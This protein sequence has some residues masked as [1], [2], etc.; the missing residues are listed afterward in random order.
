MVPEEAAGSGSNEGGTEGEQR[1]EDEG[2]RSAEEDLPPQRVFVV[3][4]EPREAILRK[5]EA[6]AARAKR[7]KERGAK[8]E[9]VRQAEAEA[10]EWAK[11]LREAGGASPTTLLFQIRGEEKK[12]QNSIKAIEQLEKRILEE[13]DEIL[14][15]RLGIQKLQRAVERHGG[16]LEASERR[17]AYLTAQK[18]AE[19]IELG[20]ISQ[21]RA[22]AAL[23]ASQR[24]EA[25]SPILEHLASILPQ[26]M[27]EMEEGDTSGSPSASGDSGT[28]EEMDEEGP[29][30]QIDWRQYSGKYAVQLQSARA[31]LRAAQKGML[32][33]VEAARGGIRETNKR[34]LGGDEPKEGDREGDVGMVPTL[35]PEQAEDLHRSRVRAAAKEYR[36]LQAMAARELVGCDQGDARQQGQRP[37]EARGGDSMA[38]SGADAATAT[39]QHGR[40][41]ENAR[42]QAQCINQWRTAEERDAERG[43]GGERGD[44]QRG[45]S[46]QPRSGRGR[47]GGPEG[48]GG[49]EGE[50]R[51]AAGR[52]NDAPAPVT[53]VDPIAAREV[54]REVDE[55]RSSIGQRMDQ[56][57]ME[58]DTNAAAE[59]VREMVET[60]EAIK[61]QERLQLLQEV[62]FAAVCSKRA[63]EAGMQTE[64]QREEVRRLWVAEMA[65]VGHGKL[66][67]TAFATYGPTGMPLE[68]Q[69]RALREA[70]RVANLGTEAAEG[71]GRGG[72]AAAGGNGP[73][74]L[75]RR[76]SSEDGSEIGGRS[77]SKSVRSR[78]GA[79]A[80]RE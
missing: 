10:E 23:L 34:S 53:P 73:W 48:D 38:P 7:A 20:K 60:N 74:N 57:R 72:G 36:H 49:A 21:L 50:R 26:E 41:E 14:K 70:I 51:E 19:S 56:V 25:Y 62:E 37:G 69:Q 31:E 58:V 45:R 2:F 75:P 54:A 65:K 44:R 9:K 64:Q 59:Q 52:Q 67:W 35:T 78:G 4:G 80:R 66:A 28:E 33:A 61:A 5:S 39:R 27:H 46:V 3:P 76:P 17:L 15:K 47:W 1:P 43:R 12:K 22:A 40:A 71:C 24:D 29:S 6:A 55:L 11:R 79:R 8:D 13:E 63:S 77:R 32:E 30:R 42:A 16:R 68:E 18:H